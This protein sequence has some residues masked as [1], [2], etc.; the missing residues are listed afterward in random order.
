M[1]EYD[2]SNVRWRK[3]SYSDG[4]GGECVEVSHDLLHAEPLAVVPVRDSKTPTAA[5]LIIPASVWTAFI[6]SVK[7]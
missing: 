3:S 5:A 7:H 1:R 4:N 2:L 6:D